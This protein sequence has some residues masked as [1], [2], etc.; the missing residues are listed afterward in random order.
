VTAAKDVRCQK[1][2]AEA[3][4]SSG[5]AS[6]AFVMQVPFPAASLSGMIRCNGRQRRLMDKSTMPLPLRQQDPV[7]L[8]HGNGVGT[9]EHE[10]LA[11]VPRPFGREACAAGQWP[12]CRS[13]SRT[14]RGSSFA[15]VTRAVGDDELLRL[16][17]VCANPALIFINAE[18]S[19]VRGA[20]KVGN[21]AAYLITT[22]LS[23]PV[24][25]LQTADDYAVSRSV[26][27]YAVPLLA[28]PTNCPAIVKTCI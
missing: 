17:I 4:N 5:A 20:R 1:G 25:R 16:G 28:L 13:A 9:A 11:R 10:L 3:R 24:P 7:L 8:S 23:P 21:R 26:R 18:Q 2:A 22:A 27:L 6:R 12:W 14:I 15:A 19:G